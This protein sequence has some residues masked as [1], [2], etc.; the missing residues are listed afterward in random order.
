MEEIIN[1][2]ENKKK[3]LEL[4]LLGD[5]KEEMIAVL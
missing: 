1:I 2:T 4:L 3:Y 5:E